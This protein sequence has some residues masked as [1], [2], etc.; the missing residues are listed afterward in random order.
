MN[1]YLAILVIL[2]G[3]SIWVNE[4]QPSNELFSI[5]TTD[6][7]IVI[8]LKLEQLRKILNLSE[9]ILLGMLTSTRLL[10]PSNA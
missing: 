2:S 1:A 5:S 6:K 9:V 8:A 7:G 4:E 10:Q 3:R